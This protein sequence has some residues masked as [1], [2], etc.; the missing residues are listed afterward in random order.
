MSE[1][2]KQLRPTMSIVLMDDFGDPIESFD[3][4]EKSELEHLREVKRLA[5]LV[6][7]TYR[8]KVAHWPEA[9]QELHAALGE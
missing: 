1:D 9:I 5:N 3:V 7:W 6:V 2:E 4:V 8:N